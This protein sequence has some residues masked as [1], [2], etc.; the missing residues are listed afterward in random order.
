[1]KDYLD[2]EEKLQEIEYDDEYDEEQNDDGLPESSS[3][4]NTNQN[5][6]NQ[7]IKESRF[8]DF[9]WFKGKGMDEQKELENDTYIAFFNDTK[10]KINPGEEV[11]F[12]YGNRGNIYLLIYYGFTLPDNKYDSF[13]FDVNMRLH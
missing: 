12:S 5:I 9:S 10:D 3:L 7:T 11:F 6:S 1:M 4:S 8:E 2:Y 13:V